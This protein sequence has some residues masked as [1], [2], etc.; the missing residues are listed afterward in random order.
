MS[1][2]NETSYY[3]IPSA[4]IHGDIAAKINFACQQSSFAFLRDLRIE[5]SDTD[6]NIDDVHVILRS[7]P[8]FLKQKSWRIDRIAPGEIVTLKDRD[9]ELDG[10]FLLNLAESVQ[11]TATFTLEAGCRVIGELSRP[12]ELLAYNEWGGIGYMPELLAAFSMPNDPAVDSILHDVVKVL[13][14][15]GR[16]DAIDGY[17]SGS[18]ARIWELA[19]A[20][21]T[22]IANL[23]IG[24]TLPPSSFEQNGQKIRLPGLVL[25]NRVATCLDT[26]MLFASV[27]EQA[28]LNPIVVLPHG[29]AFVGVWLQPEELSTIVIDDAETLRK[30]MQL[31]ELLL[32]ETTYVTQHPVLPFSKAIEAVAALIAPENDETFNAAV[33]I[34]RARAHRITPLALKVDRQTGTGVHDESVVVERPMEEAPE[35]PDFSGEIKD[36]QQDETPVGRLERWQRKLLDLS[37]RNSLLSHKSS[38]SSLHFI[39]PDVAFLE[40]KIAGGIKI[41]IRS[42]PRPSGQVQDEELHRQR[43]GEIITD[44]YA[45][46]ALDQGQ[47]LVDMDEE[48][49]SKRAVDIYRKARTALEEGGSNTLYLALGFL[50]WKHGDKKDERR[51]RAPL[52]LLPVTLERKSARSGFRLSA[53][54]DEPRFNTTLLEML[55]KDF[56]LDIRGLEGPLPT[57][58]SGIDVKGIW[59]RIR[60]EVRDVPGFEVV[61]DVVLG[62]FSFAKYLM[63]KD[64]VDRTEDLRKSA[65]VKHLIDSPRDPYPGKA[66]FVDPAKLDMEYKPSDLLTPLPADA[67]QMAAIASADKGKDFIVIG[68]PGTGKSQTIS[69]L[70]AHLLGKGKSVL[71]VSEKTAALEAVFRRLE[72]VGLGRFCLQLHSNK[73]RKAD[74]LGQL[75]NTWQQNRQA[76]VEEWEK[77]AERLRLVRD[78]LNLVVD[79]LHLR[80]RNGL[81][82]HYAIGVKVRD[83]EYASRAIFS[84]SS[85]DHH[86]KSQLA[87]MREAVEKLR[88]QYASIGELARSPFQLVSSC[89]WSP[90]WEGQLAEQAVR[91]A[92]AAAKADNACTAL[93]DNA[94]IKLPDLTIDHLDAVSEL[95]SLLAESWRKQTAYALEPDGQE[96]IDALEE[97]VSRL[98]AYAEAQASLSCAYDPMAWRRLDGDDIA[99]RWQ[100]AEQFMWPK[101][102]LA[103]RKVIKEMKMAGALGDP[104]PA[105]DAATIKHLREEGE[106]ID[107]LDGVLS[108]F[109]EW[110]GH[111]TDADAMKALE[112]IGK[113]IRSAVGRLVEDTTA[114]V[115]LRGK[116]RTLLYEGNDLLAP[117]AKVGRAVA[118]FREANS[119]LQEIC[120]RFE[121]LAGCS[122]REHFASHGKA[123]EAIRETA[124]RI[125]GHHLELR[126]WCAW[127][128]CRENA[129]DLE[130]GP[131]VEALEAGRIPVDEIERTFEAA[132]CA[133]WSAMVIGEDEV[134]RTFSTP[135]H[136]AMINKFRELDDRFQKLTADYITARL[137]GN[138]PH[139]DDIERKSSWGLL[140]R[141]IQ[142]R[143][144][145]KPV[146]QL[147]QEIPDVLTA[148]APCLMMSPLSVAQYLPADQALFD[149]VIFDEASQITVWDAVGSLARGKQVIIAGDPKQMPPSNFF[150]RSDDDPD[151]EVDIEGD[152]ESILDEMIGAS[153]P[154][155]LL[156]LHYRSRRESLIAFSNSRYYENSLVT[157]PAPVRPDLAVKLVRPE[158]FY[159][160]GKARHNEGEAKAIVAEI[161]RRL[162]HPDEQVRNQSIGVVTF[163]SEQQGLIEDLLDKARSA[164]PHI[165]PSFSTDHSLEPVFVKNLET[166]QGDERDVILFSVTYGPDQSG[167]VT[168]NFGPLNRDGGERRLN[169]ALTR[170]RF[171]MLAFSTLG[172]DRID[173]SRT[174]ARAVMD[175]K[176]FLEY[177]ERGPSVLGAAVYGPMGDFDSPFESAVARALRGRGWTIQPQIGVSAYRIDLGVVH[178]DFPG[179]YLVGIEC[180]GAMYHSSAFARERDKIRQAVLEDL[181][182]KILR[183]WSTDWWTHRTKALD[184][185]HIAL[186][187]ILEADRQ[188]SVKEPTDNFIP[189]RTT[190]IESLQAPPAVRWQTSAITN[191]DAI[192]EDAEHSYEVAQLDVERFHP[193]PDLFYTDE[194]T[195]RLTAMIDHVIEKEGPIHEEVLFRRI[196]R[197]HGF[198]RAGKNIQD[199]VLAIAKH[200]KCNSRE[201]VGLFFW[202]KERFEDRRAPARWNERDD[203]M[204]KVEYICMEEIRAIDKLLATGGD[205]V[206]LARNLGIARLSQFARERL[207]EAMG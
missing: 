134:L 95:A 178:P 55:R 143:S 71:F 164:N 165:E 144:R 122:V 41:S 151:G 58:E 198:K 202:P 204:R 23:G 201:K 19:S 146:R 150:A 8:A 170:A 115:E 75:H 89:E 44:E 149:V 49:L 163:N 133:W 72:K 28:G 123:L 11:G 113:R 35:L 156:N 3:D 205:P 109:R 62:H 68:P 161:L 60:R 103:K 172:S 141:E 56:D 104:D 135:Q 152:L 159:A 127:R 125:A 10:G 20:I 193:E 52:I 27:F 166:V 180:D 171:E 126:S 194:Y 87:G 26:T 169:V 200:R 131:L 39:C 102:L 88:V 57:D 199:I 124:E 40:D 2:D 77:E 196:A 80:R 36:E 148:L 183:I 98:K 197:F 117:D 175:L 158:G 54:D 30:R 107:R 160:R 63:W 7:S 106:A 153:I 90:Q 50:L 114:L 45:R 177:A 82:A 162:T 78:Q 145:H 108:G 174:S 5:N 138:M 195:P 119:H 206:E 140:R 184:D 38:K 21:Y 12:V 17:K 94:G 14:K 128:R 91:L 65:V 97:A 93:L 34:R 179:R 22:A 66:A 136:F 121:A 59:D 147:I 188:G 185:L 13:R 191:D 64:L 47:L 167:H 86:D 176:H 182:W 96:R 46:E 18:R 118:L 112:E 31:K 29:H 76:S 129:V 48:E 81:T 154:Q 73:A 74:V 6:S 101:S 51:F 105:R 137:S 100:E 132:Y 142:K 189:I 16:P 130:L 85:A 4:A 1:S 33:D 120:L 79:R 99:R 116:V 155:C 111:T 9:I 173:L 67:S 190:A 53:H 70:I 92:A 15:A 37:T 25:E 32:I 139:P 69:N 61:E 192:P 42:V 187:A 83:E 168:M 207:S 203:E 110:K 43:T 186:H 84:W 24:Y 157:F 181:G